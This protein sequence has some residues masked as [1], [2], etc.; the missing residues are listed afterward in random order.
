MPGRVYPIWHMP[1]T[2]DTTVFATSDGL[3][4]REA[5]FGTG[6]ERLTRA[7]G[8]IADSVGEFTRASGTAVSSS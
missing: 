4:R 5:R 7:F 8:T 2:A 6:A 3:A 1:R